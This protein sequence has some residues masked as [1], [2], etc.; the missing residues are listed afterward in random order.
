MKKNFLITVIVLLANSVFAQT[1]Q[2]YGE[3]MNQ[4]NAFVNNKQYA[5]AIPFGKKGATIVKK[6]LGEQHT[7][8]VTLIN[9]VGT[10]YF[11]INKYD[12]A[13]IFYDTT[14][15]L[16]KKYQ[17]AN[18][19]NYLQTILNLAMCYDKKADYNRAKT[20]YE[21]VVTLKKEIF[22]ADNQSYITST[23]ALST[24][25]IKLKL[26]EK[27][28]Q[29]MIDNIDYYK[30][31]KPNTEAHM[32]ELTALAELYEKMNEKYWAAIY[33]LRTTEIRY[34]LYGYDNLYCIY[35]KKAGEIFEYLTMYDAAE[36][37]YGLLAIIYE[38][39]NELEYAGYLTLQGRMLLAL[40]KLMDAEI[41]LFTAKQIFE[42][43]L[44]KENLQL[45]EVLNEIGDLFIALKFFKDAEIYYMESFSIRKK[46]LSEYTHSIAI[47]YNNLGLVYIDL[48][49]YTK[50]EEYLLKAK[51]VREKI[52]GKSHLDYAIVINN[53][54]NLYES[55]KK[56]NEAEKYYLESHSIREKINGK[57]NDRYARSLNNLGALYLNWKKAEKAKSYF[58]EAVGIVEKLYGK[59]TS[60]YINYSNN[61]AL[62]N[63]NLKFYDEAKKQ[64]RETNNLI[65]KKI[66]ENFSILSEAEKVTYSDELLYNAKFANSI[67]YNSK[68]YNKESVIDNFN[69]QLQLK[70]LVLTET[71]S[72]YEFVKNN[73]DTNFQKEYERY[74][75]LKSQIAKEYG[76]SIS[77]RAKDLPKWEDEV[78][79]REKNLLLKSINFQ[80]QQK[81]VSVSFAEVRSSLKEDEVAIEFVKFNLYNMGETDSSLYVAY[82]VTKQQDAPVFV[83]LFEKKQLQKILDS[84]G[85]T[86]QSMVNK[87]YRSSLSSKKA[88]TANF[89]N[90]LYNLIWQP[91]E[92]YLKGIK[93]VNYAPV[94]KLN[95]IAFNALAMDSNLY[96]MDKYQLNQYTSTKALAENKPINKNTQ[97][98]ALIGNP[99]FNLEEKLKEQYQQ[100][101]DTIVVKRGFNKDKTPINAWTALPGTANEINAIQSLFAKNK[102]STNS[103]S[104]VMATEENF[105][106]LNNQP[107]G[108]I[109]IATHGFF[110]PRVNEDKLS[111]VDNNTSTYQTAYDP[112]L[113]SGL[114]LNN[115]NYAWGGGI[116]PRDKEDGI[117]T[118]YE[119]SQLNL[120]KTD[121]VVLSACETALGDINGSEGVYGLQRAFKLAGVKNLVI[122]LWQ[123]PDKET[124]ELMSS[125][126]GYYLKGTPVRE[127]FYKAQQEMRSK[128]PPYYWAAFTL[129]E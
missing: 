70:A 68:N 42:R 78:Y 20:Y 62:C 118:A 107:N 96:L 74:T 34:K 90:A 91:L 89:G 6:L 1:D 114:I 46:L 88:A 128:Y 60:S 54:A 59:S 24:I 25:Y 47:S 12:S 30:K 51:V 80:Q 4:F 49:E 63:N 115:A 67:L 37:C 77:Q 71:K 45:A 109:H 82:I 116:V 65:S 10:L 104:A 72:L 121:L 124:A 92:P 61:L 16:Y 43:K 85:N 122:S 55:Q 86:N 35:Q 19:Q 129:V 106:K 58:S 15:Y 94:D 119:I 44:G 75:W 17:P 102:I 117:V 48:L 123:V 50:A 105:K 13:I 69:Q 56:F 11:F 22:G 23:T 14:L 84:A 100:N 113:R 27:A 79:V 38:K 83:P 2:E 7:N 26:Y 93:K 99:N 95:S 52:S 39:K 111:A 53:L 33:Y 108:I 29:L 110:L 5:A 31:F 57:N 66:K 32:D 97:N 73:T 76:Q 103:Y 120:N 64:V 81:A 126:Y 3:C 21:E 28:E 40:D 8:Y 41:K 112:M 9:T 87:L 18:K 127:A 101:A 125:F 36:S 98:I